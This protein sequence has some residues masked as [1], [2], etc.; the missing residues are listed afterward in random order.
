[1]NE[2][3]IHSVREGLETSSVILNVPSKHQGRR[4][5]FSLTDKYTNE[6]GA[7]IMV[8]QATVISAAP[9]R[10]RAVE[11]DAEIGDIVYWVAGSNNEAVRYRIVDDRIMHNPYLV[12]ADG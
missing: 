1:M 7:P 6:H 12:P 9:I 3:T 8:A 2:H 5:R 10:K 4:T 11:K